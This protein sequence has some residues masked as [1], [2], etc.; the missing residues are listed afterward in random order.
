M[1]QNEL[2]NVT[3]NDYLE[4]IQANP[5]QTEDDSNSGSALG[6]L[7]AGVVGAL[8]G[9]RGGNVG[10]DGRVDLVAL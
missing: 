4:D 5:E 1:E 10:V 9:G 6:K 8:G 3:E 2:T 7:I